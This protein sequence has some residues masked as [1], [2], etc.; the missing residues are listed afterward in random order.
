[1]YAH[2]H[3]ESQIEGQHGS[4]TIAD[5]GQGNTH[6]RQDADDHAHVDE[7]IGKEGQRDRTR[8]QAGKV[9]GGIGRNDKA[10]PHDE[11]VDGE[12]NEIAYQ[13]EFFRMYGE[14]KVGGA[15]GQEFQM[16]LRAV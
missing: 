13:A 14:N 12:Q 9:G 15:F 1:M 7:S 4:A 3:A 11:H 10:A 16:G 2:Q 6:D 8:H 5:Q